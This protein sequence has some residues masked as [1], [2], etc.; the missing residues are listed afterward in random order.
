[1]DSHEG[2]PG[3]REGGLALGASR[4][5]VSLHI[6]LKLRSLKSFLA[7]A[8]GKLYCQELLESSQE[9]GHFPEA[10]TIVRIHLEAH[11]D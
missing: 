3:P 5:G 2:V 9:G 8:V 7:P 1:M 10:G 6:K 4:Q 11:V